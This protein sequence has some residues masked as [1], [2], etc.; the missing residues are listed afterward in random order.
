MSDQ[1]RIYTKTPPAKSTQPANKGMLYRSAIRSEKPSAIPPIVHEVLK[2]PGQPLEASTRAFMEPRF[3]HDFSQ[4]RVHTDARAAESA[5]EVN[6]LAYTVGQ[7]IVFGEGQY[8]PKTTVG[9]KLMA[10]E[11]AHVV[12]NQLHPD[13]KGNGIA[14]EN[15]PSEQEA[16][17]IAHD[18]SKVPSSY[19]GG[20]I[21]RQPTATQGNIQGAI[22]GGWRQIGDL[23][24]ETLRT[25]SVT[26]RLEMLAAL[27]QAYW[28]GGKEEEAII[29]ILSTTPMNQAFELVNKLTEQTVGGK[30]YL[31]E[32][33]RVVDSENNLELHNILSELRLKA[34]GSEKGI[35]ALQNA[36]IL[37]WHDVM[38]IFEDNATFFFSRTSNGKVNIKYDVKTLGSKDFADEIQKLPLDIF[39]SG[40]TYEPDQVLVIHDYDKG[41]FIPVV[42]Q[43]LIGYQHLGVRGFLTHVTTVASLVTPVGA[44]KTV[45]G[46][47]ALFTLERLLPTIFVLVDENRLNLVKWFPK[48]GPRM[49]Y[50]SDLA[51]KYVAAYG[52]L[53]LSLSGWTLLRSWKEVRQARN[54]LEGVHASSEAEKMAAALE[55]QADEIFDQAEKLRNSE[56][57]GTQAAKSEG[58]PIAGTQSHSSPTVNS[59]ESVTIQPVSSVDQSSR[60]VSEG[61]GKAHKTFVDVP[62]DKTGKI[63]PNVKYQTGLNKY[64]YETDHLGRIEKF[65]TDDLKLTTRNKRLPHDPNTPGKQPGDHA[66]HLAGDRFD[67]S[68]DIDN[69]VSQSSKVNQSTYKKIEDEWTRALKAKP[70]KH[71]TVEVKINYNGDSLRPSSF[72]VTYTIDGELKVID[73]IN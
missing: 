31:S 63:K 54:A 62:F 14:P 46:K 9:K 1:T 50:Y 67:G 35:N 42:A 18:V 68:P 22:Q 13:F 32:L 40:H 6:A 23:N 43:E 30:P 52:F 12:Q 48:W 61:T 70:P 36:P 37:P 3:G 28:T 26:E 51:Q 17:L 7:D 11:L 29:R 5:R 49:I 41:R 10:H 20:A 19:P 72:N 21:Q 71:V 16:S 27:I 24:E 73:I 55:R 33:D 45:I 8:T 59:K 60:Y 38:G 57:A 56:I 4:V 65:S 44:A 39:T 34:K 15:H 2:S 64:D 53:R 58:A 25:A 66:G 69:L 47:A